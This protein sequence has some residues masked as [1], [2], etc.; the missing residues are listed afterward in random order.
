ML[1][2]TPV[3][4]LFDTQMGQKEQCLLRSFDAVSRENRKF[5]FPWERDTRFSEPL[6]YEERKISLGEV[7]DQMYRFAVYAALSG[8][9]VHAFIASQRKCKASFLYEETPTLIK[10]ILYDITSEEGGISRKNLVRLIMRLDVF[11]GM[12]NQNGMN[13]LQSIPE[14]GWWAVAHVYLRALSNKKLEWKSI[15]ETIDMTRKEFPVNEYDRLLET[16]VKVSIRINLPKWDG[17][18]NDFTF[19]LRGALETWQSQS[20][21]D[22]ESIKFAMMSRLRSDVSRK[23]KNGGTP[24]E[25]DLIE[26]SEATIAIFEKGEEAS[27][28]NSKFFRFL[29]GAYEGGYRYESNKE[30][31]KRKELKESEKNVVGD[32]AVNQ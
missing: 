7:I 4:S 22:K 28:M 12:I 17:S 30:W 1:V 24:R 10:E 13:G 19:M 14:F 5:V 9:P 2:S 26:F 8:E 25:E 31:K 32:V 23:N 20:V 18:T 15:S 3:Q 16:L 29:L 21:F 6:M 27:D 11:R